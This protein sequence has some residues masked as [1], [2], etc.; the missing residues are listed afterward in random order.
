MNAK[1]VDMTEKTVAGKINPVWF[2]ERKK[3]KSPPYAKQVRKIYVSNTGDSLFYSVDFLTFLSLLYAVRPMPHSS[4][5]H[6]YDCNHEMNH[7][8]DEL[9]WSLHLFSHLLFLRQPQ[10]GQRRGN[11]FSKHNKSPQQAQWILTASAESIFIYKLQYNGLI[12][13]LS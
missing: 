2:V 4:I 6:H 5:L 9:R 3:K 11:V 13:V 10:C 8:E 12:Q 7:F 1:M